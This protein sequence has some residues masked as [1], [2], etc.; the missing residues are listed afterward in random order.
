MRRNVALPD[1]TWITKSFP[2]MTPE[3]T[4]SLPWPTNERLLPLG[5]AAVRAVRKVSRSCVCSTS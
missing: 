3:R 5:T 2:A 4:P 1:D